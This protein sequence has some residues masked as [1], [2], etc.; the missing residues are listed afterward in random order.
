[1]YFKKLLLIVLIIFTE[2]NIFAQ[3]AIEN[4]S[5]E[6]RTELSSLIVE[7]KVIKLNS[8]RSAYSKAIY[9]ATVI[10]VYK[11]FKGNINGSKTIE[12]IT[13]GGQIGNELHR[14]DPELELS[15]DETGVFL[16]VNN[17]VKLSD[18]IKN[19]G[20][21]EFQGVASLQSLIS[22]DLMYNKAFDGEKT[23]YGIETELYEKLQDL[24]GLKFYEVKNSA[25]NFNLFKN[26]KLSSPEIKSFVQSSANSGTGDILTIKGTGFRNTRGNGRIEFLDANYGDGRRVKTPFAAD[27]KVWN[28]TMISVRIPTRA[29]TGTISLATYDS[30]Y[31]TTSTSFKINFA[32]LNASFAPSGGSTQY[33]TTDHVNDNGKGGYTFQMNYRFKNN[34]NMVN[35]FLK[36]LETWR[37]QTFMNWEVGRDTSINKIEPDQVNIVKLTKNANN[38]LATCYSYWNGCYVSGT[39]M[40]WYV[41]ELDIEADST[42]NWYY[43]T[44]NPSG[45]QYDFQSVISHELGHGHQLGHVIASQEMMHWSISPGQK[46]S[47]LSSNDIAGGTYVKDKSIKMNVC[48]GAKL[49]ALNSTNCGYTKPTAGFKASL[50]NICES[51]DVVFTDTS[52]GIIKTYLWKF[53]NGASSASK[54]GKGPHTITYST[55]GFKTIKLFTTNDFGTDSTVKTNYIEILP[56]KPPMPQNL[57]FKDTTCIGTSTYVVDTFNGNYN[58]TW[59]FPPEASEIGGGKYS[60]QVNWTSSGGPFKIL[61][62]SQNLCGSS[63]SLTGSVWVMNNPVPSFTATENGREVTFTNT[64]QFADSYKWYFGDSDSS[65]LLNPVHIYPLGKAYVAVLKATNICKTVVFSKTVN[66]YHPAHIYNRAKNE[67][68]FSPNPVVDQILTSEK[69]LSYKIFDIAGKELL[70]GDKKNINFEKF[71]KGFYILNLKLLNGENLI[72]KIIKKG[73]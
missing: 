22:Y 34:N 31:F 62:K 35:T 43:G 56:T 36:S 2:K 33:F 71:E 24:T 9:T 63:D 45:S 46:K 61:V 72:F 59:L 47:S 51:K 21:P 14:A 58:L 4:W 20:I 60:K 39:E 16:L 17:E 19:N 23:Y 38:V 15:K 27:Y 25:I 50:L 40:E 49:I 64:S 28:D 68:Y 37:C 54:T 18:N 29:G 7:G 70:W 13:F 32:H 30:N 26:R 69:V 66:P 41:T 48:S 52:K 42:R 10:E 73:E 6:K 44:G 11:I 53:D 57:K 8:F 1:M 67:I 55:T 12:I 3:C 5:I 65:S